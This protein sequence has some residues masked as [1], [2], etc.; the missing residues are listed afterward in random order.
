M[1][2]ERIKS[3]VEVGIFA[4]MA[5]VL[6]LIANTWGFVNGGSISIA[7]LP[8]FVV[9]FRRGLKNGLIAGLLLGGLQILV[10]RTYFLV[11]LQFFLDYIAAF[12]VIGFAGFFPKAITKPIHLV[13]GIVVATFARLLAAS[14]A[15]IAYWSEYIPDGIA[16][17]DRV[18]GTAFSSTLITPTLMTWVGS[19]VYNAAYLIPSAILCII[20]GL[21]LQKRGILSYH[22][23]AE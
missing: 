16:D 23:I 6:D 15:G 3:L 18:F 13:L 8:I 1:N 19:F 17:I 21:V 14:W 12:I 20:I 4:S 22:L 10:T 9:A 5:L 2:Q 7:M 11:P